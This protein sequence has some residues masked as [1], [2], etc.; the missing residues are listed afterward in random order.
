MGSYSRTSS[1]H[2]LSSLIGARELLSVHRAELNQPIHQIAEG[3]LLAPIRTSLTQM[4]LSSSSHCENI[5][6]HAILSSCLK[7]HAE[8]RGHDLPL[9]TGKRQNGLISRIQSLA[10]LLGTQ[11]TTFFALASVR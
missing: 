4:G 11:S 9:K 7:N 3:W 10:K 1:T 5:T 6:A 8:L 2:D